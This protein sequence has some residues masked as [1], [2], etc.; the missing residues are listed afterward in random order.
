[1]K[2]II[3]EC[4]DS[5]A[6]ALDEAGNF[7][8]VANLNYEAGQT[9]DKVFKM[10]T[11][12]KEEV[13]PPIIKRLISFAAIAAIFFLV[14]TFGLDYD[15]FDFD[16]ISVGSV[17]LIINPEVK[18]DVN[19]KDHVVN[20]EGL[21]EDGKNLIKGYRYSK[22]KVSLVIDE[23]IDLAI[24]KGYL[25]DHGRLKL[26]FD[27]DSK[28]WKKE[29]RVKLNKHFKE[30]L[31]KTRTFVIDLND[32][33]LELEMDESGTTKTKTDYKITLPIKKE[34]SEWKKE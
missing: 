1:M 5:Y 26:E 23:L 21:N 33:D 29:T 10:Q 30:E 28:T 17:H 16:N 8:T 12:E 24:K 19:K 34:K 2:Y 15:I 25:F 4:H 20:L 3:M 6:V 9:V 18:I 31:S 13:K 14:V 22:K 7:I 32:D 11:F 27:A